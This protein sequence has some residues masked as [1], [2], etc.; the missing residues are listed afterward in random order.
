V[1]NDFRYCPHHPDSGFSGEIANLKILC[2]CRKPEIGLVTDLAS[3]YNVDFSNSFVIGD[4]DFDFYL[5]E[6]IGAKFI[7][8]KSTLSSEKPIFRFENLLLASD[9]ISKSWPQ[10]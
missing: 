9:Y 2:H 8:I 1:I 4:T 3:E 7:G 10:L 5:S 6:N